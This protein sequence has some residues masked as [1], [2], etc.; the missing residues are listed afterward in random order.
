MG[1]GGV[2]TPLTGPRWVGGCGS[3]LPEPPAPG[4]GVFVSDMEPLCLARYFFFFGADFRATRDAADLRALT[5]VPG[6][7][8]PGFPLPDVVFLAIAPPVW[9]SRADCYQKSSRFSVA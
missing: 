4:F 5:R 2:G 3:G 9:D 6:G 1:C 8:R 7:C